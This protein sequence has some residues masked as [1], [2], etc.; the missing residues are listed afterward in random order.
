MELSEN[1]QAIFQVPGSYRIY[2]TL[3][4]N[5]LEQFF[6]INSPIDSAYVIISSGIDERNLRTDTYYLKMAVAQSVAEE[7]VETGRKIFVLGQLSGLKNGINL[8]NKT[9]NIQRTDWN[10]IELPYTYTHSLTPATYSVEKTDTELPAGEVL[11]YSEILGKNVPIFRSY[12]QDINKEGEISLSKSWQ[13]SY[14]WSLTRYQKISGK[15]YVTGQLVCRGIGDVKVRLRGKN[16]NLQ[17]STG[18][19]TTK[20]G[21]DLIEITFKSNGS[22]TLNLSFVYDE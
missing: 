1:A 4:G 14:S 3:N 5:T 17:Q 11:V 9:L 7:S 2:Y 21:S 13:I 10:L 15:F 6:E 20:K 8:K 19:T 12:M 18:F 16:I 22:T